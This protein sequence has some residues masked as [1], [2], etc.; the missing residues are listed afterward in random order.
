MSEVSARM[1]ARQ[2]VLQAQKTRRQERAAAEKRREGWGMDVAVALAERDDAVRRHEQVAGAGLV[3]LVD[4]GLS[5]EEAVRWVGEV[6]SVKEARAL[7]AGYR[8]SRESTQD[9][10]ETPVSDGPDEDE[11]R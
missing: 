6:V 2:R 11:G 1:A 4:D 7:M 8:E 10:A 9:A 3:K 5:V